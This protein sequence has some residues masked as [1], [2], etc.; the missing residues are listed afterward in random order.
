MVSQ[1]ENSKKL[2]SK[3]SLRSTVESADIPALIKLDLCSRLDVLRK[4]STNNASGE[5][6]AQFK[7][8]MKIVKACPT[9]PKP[10]VICVDADCNT[11]PKMLT[12][13]AREL[14]K[15]F[16]N[17]AVM[18]FL[19]G[20]DH[21]ACCAAVPKVMQTTS[22]RANTWVASMISSNGKYGGQGALAQGYVTGELESNIVFE[23]LKSR[24]NRMI[25]YNITFSPD[26][27]IK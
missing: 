7:K 23:T 15:N 24:S 3:S 6:K 10:V 4:N 19:H 14:Q 22:F 11:T 5:Q 20:R 12:K 9:E 27:D 26:M 8:V 1:S 21:I 18:L 17:N 13:Y 16:P 25:D 2:A